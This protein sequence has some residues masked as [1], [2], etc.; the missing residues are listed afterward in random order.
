[1]EFM[2]EIRDQ[3]GRVLITPCKPSDDDS[4]DLWID[5]LHVRD[6]IVNRVGQ[7]IYHV[8]TPPGRFELLP[9]I[10]QFEGTS[11]YVIDCGKSWALTIMP[12]E[13]KRPIRSLVIEPD[14]RELRKLVD[15]SAA[16]AELRSRILAKMP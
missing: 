2:T 9:R 14:I 3:R 15:P 8:L 5:E 13:E 10:G 6:C 7:E 12:A 4:V 1:M 16:S 11:V